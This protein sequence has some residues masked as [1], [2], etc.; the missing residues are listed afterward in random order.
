MKSENDMLVCDENGDD[1]G[2][3][4]DAAVDEAEADD[5]CAK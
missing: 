2:C 1:V 5:D 3:V 4:V